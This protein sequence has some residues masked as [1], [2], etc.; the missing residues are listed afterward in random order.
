MKVLDQ[1]IYDAFLK[2]ATHN[3]WEDKKKVWFDYMNGMDKSIGT[4]GHQ[5]SIFQITTKMR[6][7]G[8]HRARFLEAMVHLVPEGTAKFRKHLDKI[9]ELDN[10][11]LQMAFHD[12]TTAEADA[13]IGCDGLK[14]Q[15]RH[16]LVGNDNPMADHVYTYM[17]AYR[18]LIDMD[19]AVKAI[20]AERA[21]NSCMWVSQSLL[22]PLK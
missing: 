19:T 4:A 18:G 8:V 7:N 22:I 20:G 12:G 1:G 5:D 10:G 16:I 2:V 14:S 9:T 21:Q 17:Y 6:V 13:V 11:R 3:L 15:V